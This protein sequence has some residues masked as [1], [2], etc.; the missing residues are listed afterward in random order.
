[1][2]EEEKQQFDAMK[3]TIKN[4]GAQVADLERQVNTDKTPAGIMDTLGLRIYH[5]SVQFKKP[6]ILPADATSI[7]T[8]T[9]ASDGQIVIRLDDGTAANIPYYL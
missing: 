2:T 8:D 9:T 3:E 5:K 1:M 6:L 7:P 4:L